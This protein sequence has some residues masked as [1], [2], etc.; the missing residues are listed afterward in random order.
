MNG[1]PNLKWLKCRLWSLEEEE[2]SPEE[3]EEQEDILE[4]TN[5]NRF[6]ERSVL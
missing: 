1:T 5:E 2:D 3:E 6:S 4:D